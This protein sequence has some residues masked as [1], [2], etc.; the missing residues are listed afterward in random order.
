MSTE[1]TRDELLARIVAKAQRIRRRRAQMGAAGVICMVAAALVVPAWMGVARRDHK[2]TGIVANPPSVVAPST[3]TTTMPHT[4]TTAV[5]GAPPRQAVAVVNGRLALVSTATGRIER[6]IT[7]ALPGGG[8]SDPTLTPDGTTVY[9][10]RGDG[11]CAAHLA[12][13][14]LDGG[15]EQIVVA[16]RDNSVNSAP[17]L[18]ADGRWLTY[19][20][21]LCNLQA[22]APGRDSVV[23]RDLTTRQER[24]IEL[25]PEQGVVPQRALNSD[26]TRVLT[27]SLGFFSVRDV[28]SGKSLLVVDDANYCFRSPTWV[29][30]TSIA[31]IDTCT[32]GKAAL[33]RIDPATGKHLSDVPLFSA[34]SSQILFERHGQHLLLGLTEESGRSTYFL[35]DGTRTRRLGAFD[36]I[37]W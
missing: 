13:V 28:G 33:V 12:S 23:I 8:A 19:R 31:L 30:D 15:P 16:S 14:S 6:Y 36:G 35:V 29:D 11:T 1:P 25:D 7:E 26:G 4:T 3:T 21:S 20:H 5:P 24:R 22:G 27:E 2:T 18:S 17:S 10:S 37:T 34:K 9:F 32:P